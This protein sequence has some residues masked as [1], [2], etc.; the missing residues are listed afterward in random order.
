MSSTIHGTLISYAGI[1][2]LLLGESGTGKSRL[3]AEGLMLGAKLIADDQIVLS[4]MSGLLMG[5]PSK[6]LLGVLE[7]RGV[8]LIK[9]PDTSA[10]HVVHVAV[11]LDAAH[12]S[13][14]L[15]APTTETYEGVTIP[16]LA[17]PPHPTTS[18]LYL[19]S[20]IRAV[21]EGRMLPQDWRPVA[22]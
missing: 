13:E 11:K 8:G 7:M 16:L 4:T 19:L 10:Q 3:A 22:V 5:A 20:V 17:L 2:C 12:G 9:L 15:P 18:A 21:H 6:P 14:R 1:G